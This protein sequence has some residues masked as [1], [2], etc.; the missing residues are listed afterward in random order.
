MLLTIIL[1][2]L[3]LDKL[4]FINKIDYLYLNKK[5]INNDY[6]IQGIY[7]YDYI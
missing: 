5:Y 3:S 4:I 2:E 6:T 7:T 1:L